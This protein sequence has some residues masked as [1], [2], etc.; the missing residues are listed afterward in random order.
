MVP[1]GSALATLRVEA[2]LSSTTAANHLEIEEDILNDIERGAAQA[3]TLLLASMARLYHASPHR[4]VKAYLV[5]R[6]DPARW[7]RPRG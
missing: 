7:L 4:V 1:L 2:E 5:D 6:R 3:S